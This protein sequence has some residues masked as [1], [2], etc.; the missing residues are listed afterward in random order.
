[1]A[2]R[3]DAE[4]DGVEA[5]RLPDVGITATT[6]S[7]VRLAPGLRRFADEEELAALAARSDLALRSELMPSTTGIRRRRGRV[8]ALLRRAVGWSSSIPML[9]GVNDRVQARTRRALGKNAFK[10]NLITTRPAPLTDLAR[11]DRGV[12]GSRPSG[13]ARDRPPHARPRSMRR[14][15]SPHSRR[16]TPA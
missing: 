13:C 3:A 11:G 16:T 4:L 10:V 1:M 2:W 9:A 15:P 12:R 6:I 8:P 7:T 5:R 14:A